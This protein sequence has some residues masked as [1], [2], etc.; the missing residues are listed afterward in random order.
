M[1]QMDFPEQDGPVGMLHAPR[2]KTAWSQLSPCG[3]CLSPLGPTQVRI[4]EL[5]NLLGQNRSKEFGGRSLIGPP[6]G[7][8]SHILEQAVH[9]PPPSFPYIDV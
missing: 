1:S 9:L 6:G 5:G 8:V 2:V 3:M 7:P 4:T